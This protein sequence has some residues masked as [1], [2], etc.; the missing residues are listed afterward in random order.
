M[1]KINN[2]TYFLLFSCCVPVKGAK[3]SIIC[4]LQRRTFLYITNGICEILGQD[5]YLLL[6]DDKDDIKDVLDYL[7][8]KEMGF[9]TSE[10]HKFPCIN[11]SNEDF[12][13]I[14][15]N[16]VIDYDKC[17]KHDLNNIV[18]QISEVG[19]SVVGLRYFDAIAYDTLIEHLSTF[20]LSPVRTLHLLL[21]ETS[22]T[23]IETLTE[24]CKNN[25]RIAQ[26]IVHSAFKELTQRLDLKT[27]IYKATE[28]VDNALNCGCISPYYFNSNIDFFKESLFFNNC[29]HKKISIDTK[30]NIKNCSASNES[31]GNIEKEKIIPILKNHTFK[32]KWHI[33][34]DEIE[35]CKDCEF[36]YICP[37]CRT[38]ICNDKNMYS[39]PK[40][41]NYDPYTNLWH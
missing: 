40:K 7:V 8:E 35:T 1:V 10:P 30:G 36:R 16:T 13:S 9:F 17:S 27:V 11:F 39:K 12:P 19:C 37:D 28:I 29:L 24:I 22:W 20:D 2:N 23:S 33:K 6:E 34:K 15:K 5:F 32:E 38:F 14:I 41:C 3:R 25:K 4:D 31:F 26:I 18:L 21:K